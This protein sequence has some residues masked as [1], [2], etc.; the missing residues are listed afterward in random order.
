MEQQT[1]DKKRYGTRWKRWLAVYVAIG[2][3]VYLIVY[4]AFFFHHGAGG[5]Y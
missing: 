5:G 4:F 1:S 3:I 2:V